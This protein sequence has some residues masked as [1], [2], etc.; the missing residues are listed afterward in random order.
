MT[1]SDEWE[2]GL[3]PARSRR[4]RRPQQPTAPEPLEPVATIDRLDRTIADLAQ[5]V[6]RQTILIERLSLQMAE[7]K[8][9]L[10]EL[11]S[12]PTQKPDAF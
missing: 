5:V 7:V 10:R 4:T 12:P 2:E 1:S 3:T 6:R 11:P 8:Q 9:A